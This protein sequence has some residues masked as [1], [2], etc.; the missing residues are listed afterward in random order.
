MELASSDYQVSVINKERTL[1]ED[2]QILGD[3]FI[4]RVKPRIRSYYRYRTESVERILVLCQAH[5]QK[6]KNNEHNL[7]EIEDA[8]RKDLIQGTNKYKVLAYVSK[9]YKSDAHKK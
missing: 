1:F 9:F 8:F 6:I 3:G 2:R 5:N 7:Q 4:K